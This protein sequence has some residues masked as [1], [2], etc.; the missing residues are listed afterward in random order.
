MSRMI[1][2]PS[3][4]DLVELVSHRDTMDVEMDEVLVHPG[5]QL[6]GKSLREST[7]RDFDLLVVAAKK[8]EGDFVFNPKSDYV[9]S[10]GDTIILMGHQDDLRRYQESQR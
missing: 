3:T 2:K 4:A 10:P 5:S 1:M 6:I 9:F 8:K 7:A